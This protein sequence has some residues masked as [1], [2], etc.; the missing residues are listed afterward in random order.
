MP[1][2]TILAKLNC[3]WEFFVV[4]LWLMANFMNVSVVLFRI[5]CIL[6]SLLAGDPCFDFLVPEVDLLD[7]LGAAVGSNW[8]GAV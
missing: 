8:P 1:L 4:L 6:S 7:C 2:A 3:F 5:C